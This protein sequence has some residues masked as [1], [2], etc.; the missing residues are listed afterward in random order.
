MVIPGSHKGPTYD[1]HQNGAFIGA[2]TD[3]NFKTD[4]AVQVEVPAGGISIHHVRTLHGSYP[5]TSPNPRR[6]LLFQ[7]C[8]ID[9]WPLTGSDWDVFNDY[10][11]RGEPT[12]DI[13]MTDAP[14]RMPRP[15]AER[16]G[17]I[18]EVQS[19]MENPIL[20]GQIAEKSLR[21]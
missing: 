11:L 17:S 5:N 18:Y 20:R 14:V 3:P 15:Y 4:N 1:H 13:R 8:A 21:V 16:G 12:Q 7:Y 19:L 6:L 10:I 9:A 2:V